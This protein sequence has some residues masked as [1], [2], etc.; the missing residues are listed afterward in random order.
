M[1]PTSGGGMEFYM[2]KGIFGKIKNILGKKSDNTGSTDE[3]L[4]GDGELLSVNESL[5]GLD[6]PQYRTDDERLRAMMQAQAQVELPVSGLEGGIRWS[7]SKE[8]VLTISPA[9]GT[10]MTNYSS[11]LL[12]DPD[13]AS[14]NIA[15]WL[16]DKRGIMVNRL[17]IEEGIINIGSNSF[18]TCEFLDE[19]QLPAS[20]TVIGEAAFSD[21]TSLKKIAIPAGVKS[22]PTLAF[23]RCHSLCEVSLPDDLERIENL[24]FAECHALESIHIPEGV[25]HVGESAFWGCPLF[26][27]IDDFIEE[28]ANEEYQGDDDDDDDDS[29]YIFDDDIADDDGS[30]FIID[31]GKGDGDSVSDYSEPSDKGDDGAGM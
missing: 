25:A 28:A 6:A 16:Q 24:A 13:M 15:P 29:V 26:K 9:D 12:T 17:V 27:S 11:P 31:N 10:Q 20:L 23:W 3:N 2:G 8:Q 7:I 19:V 1:P 18:A 4:S 5:S 21:C 30:V 22:I 14:Y